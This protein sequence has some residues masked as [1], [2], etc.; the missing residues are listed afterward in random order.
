M[1]KKGKKVK[2]D[3]NSSTNIIDIETDVG[4]KLTKDRVD[5]NRKWA[6]TK[7]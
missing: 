3:K 4:E 2:R 7:N 1:P 5:Q 6:L